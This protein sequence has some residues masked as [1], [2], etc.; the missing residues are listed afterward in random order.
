[1]DLSTVTDIIKYF[2]KARWFVPLGN[3]KW[4][5]ATGVK[6]E[7]VSEM[8][9]WEGWEGSLGAPSEEGNGGVSSF[10][11]SCVPAQ[12]TSGRSGLDKDTTLWCGWVIERFVEE[13]K[14]EAGDEAPKTTRK[15]AVYHA[16]DTGY[17]RI[18]KSKTVCPAFEQIGE[19]FGGFDL[20]F[21]PIWR[22]GTLGFISYLGFRLSHHDIPSA[23]HCSPTDAVAIHMDVKSWN[24]IGI[25]FGTFI[26]SE[27]ESHDALIEFCEA[28]HAF[29]VSELQDTEDDGVGRAGVLDIGGSL[30]VK[31]ESRVHLPPTPEEIAD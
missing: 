5:L 14:H 10:K 11:V 21:L 26:G 9:C 13:S 8:D 1:L 27:H 7:L 20:S 28:R 23:T 2:P 17:R 16:G 12:H 19:K 24:S 6:A 25:H 4:L 31:I 22:G 3:K 30:A 29:G 15:G 18:T